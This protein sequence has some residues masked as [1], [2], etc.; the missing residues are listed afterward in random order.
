M[1]QSKIE[2]LIYKTQDYRETSKMLF[3][4]TSRG[5]KTLVATGAN[6]INSNM[7]YVGQYLTQ[8]SFE[9]K[10]K[11][12]FQVYFL[13]LISSFDEI[14]K[15]YDKMNLASV[16]TDVIQKFIFDNDRHEIY[17]SEI[18]KVLNSKNFKE[19]VLSFL[20]K[21]LRPLGY[22]MD[23][24]PNGKA[25]RGFSINEG[26]LIYEGEPTT[27]DVSIDD[28]ITLLKLMRLPYDEMIE[29]EIDDFNRIKSYIKRYYEYHIQHQFKQL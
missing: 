2:G 3:V 5:K 22:E 28:T 29:L 25:V 9:D 26:R 17:Y 16:L 4:Y 14:K 19:S 21:I 1:K 12:M 23:I 11:E 7:R 20:V 8:V 24:I 13:D 27:Y 18:I 15:D 6:K 10:D